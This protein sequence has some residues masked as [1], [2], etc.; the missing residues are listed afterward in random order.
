MISSRGDK[1]P[2]SVPSVAHYRPAHQVGFVSATV[3]DILPLIPSIL[4]P[5]LVELVLIF[6]G[7]LRL[8]VAVTCYG[9]G[10]PEVFGQDSPLI[11]YRQPY[12]L[13]FRR[14]MRSGVVW[15]RG[16]FQ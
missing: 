4:F 2:E 8:H 14:G 9:H 7:S 1:P 13:Q 12:A 6:S 16:V 11:P 3:R 15:L 5:T 10:V